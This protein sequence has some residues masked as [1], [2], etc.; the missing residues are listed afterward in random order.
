MDRRDFFK[1]ARRKRTSSVGKTGNRHSFFSGLTPYAGPWGLNEV[2][3]LLKR[4]MFGAK[5]TD[6]DYFLGLS[7]DAAI[8]ELLNTTM[9]ASPPVRDYGL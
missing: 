6:C 9:T 2:T 3:H 4:T 8:D 7:P 5:K 1:M